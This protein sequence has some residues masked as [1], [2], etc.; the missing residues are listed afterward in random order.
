MGK[1]SAKRWKKKKNVEAET[2]EKGV[3][4]QYEEIVKENADFE[5]YY[6]LQKICPE[7]E[8]ED[9]M[10]HLRESLPTTFRI[11]GSRTEGRA[12]LHVLQKHLIKD[13][14]LAGKSDPEADIGA[15]PLP[16]YPQNLGWQINLTR[17]DIRRNEAY[18]RLHNFL[19]S[20]TE[21]GNI[22]RQEAVSMIPPLALQV[23]PHHRVL[24]LCAAPGSKTAQLIEMIHGEDEGI[25]TDGF[26]VANDL[27]NKRCY[28]LVHQGK[29]LLSPAFIVTNHDASRYP[30][31]VKTDE[32]GVLKKFKF[33]RV[34]CDVP[35]SGD[36]TIRK[37]VDVWKKWSTSNGLY[38]HQVQYQVLKRGLELL[39]VGGKLV[40]ST[41]SLNPIE[42]EGVLHRMLKDAEG[43]V[44]LLDIDLPHLKHS[45][46]MSHWIPCT[47]DMVQYSKFE[48]VPEK[49][50][51][52]VRPTMFPPTPEE[53]PKYHLDKCVRVLP[54]KQDTGGFFIA[55][56]TK[57]RLLPWENTEVEVKSERDP[58]PAAKRDPRGPPKKIRRIGG[59][60]E[61]PYVFMS[62]DNPIW[63]QL[64]DFYGLDTSLD[65]TNFLRRSEDGK[66]K[67][68]YITTKAVRDF[69]RSNE[70]DVKIINVGV[71]AL[72]RVDKKWTPCDF[73]L[74]QEGL[75]SLSP[76]IK[77]RRV[78]LPKEDLK[79]VL[80]NDDDK[81]KPPLLEL[82][83]EETR[84]LVEPIERGSLVLDIDLQVEDD[85]PLCKL[86]LVGWKGTN[87]L[88]AY[89]QR[90]DRV[91]YLRLCGADVSKY[92]KNKFKEREEAEAAELKKGDAEAEGNDNSMDVEGNGNGAASPEE[93][94][95][96][97]EPK[98]IK[99]TSS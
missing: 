39:E 79:A 93:S 10:K 16:W 35:C 76:F 74:S 92:E 12:L 6:K 51:T 69:V 80:L 60:K 24:D 59:F 73:R 22:S 81:D 94:S 20:E 17:K 70:K 54:H 83:T 64:R 85:G 55:L 57:T 63:P 7:N 97:I 46:G 30:D 89:I 75:P 71:K 66:I 88:R 47:R 72:V 3:R 62:E 27:D 56:L 29:R 33:D 5:T 82:L 34:L 37:N 8:W 32:N 77:D 99:V 18:F 53:A 21:T 84:K 15:F 49:W 95:D 4:K 98:P 1:S 13:A 9:M 61:D 42:D 31:V 91:H 36:G 19:I 96:V 41:C 78:Q 50:Q 68:I 11:T 90:N 26:V 65:C 14:V 45:K 86:Q 25:K 28:M 58:P 38:L 52:T 40:Y 43:S 23:E 2:N 48:D 44:E 67:N 87:S